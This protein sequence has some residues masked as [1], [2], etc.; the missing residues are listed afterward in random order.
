MSFLSVH[1]K[2][3]EDHLGVD[4]AKELDKL[5]TAVFGKPKDVEP[6]DDKSE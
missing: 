5:H 2:A 3:L 4:V 1:L 6:E